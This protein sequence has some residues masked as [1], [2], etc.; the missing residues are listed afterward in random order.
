MQDK[1]QMAR[2][3]AS[4]QSNKLGH[5][6]GKST[7]IISSPNRESISISCSVVSDFLQPHG[8]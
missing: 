6:S 3:N 8:L 2:T 7:A 4:V 1:T 5:K